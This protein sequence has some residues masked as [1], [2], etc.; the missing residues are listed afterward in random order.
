MTSFYGNLTALGDVLAGTLPLVPAVFL[1]AAGCSSEGFRLHLLCSR[2]SSVGSSCSGS[3]WRESR[4]SLWVAA[5]RRSMAVKSALPFRC[6]H[7]TILS[8][9]ALVVISLH[10]VP[11][12]FA[13]GEMLISCPIV[14]RPF[15]I[16]LISSMYSGCF[17]VRSS[18]FLSKDARISA[19]RFP[20]AV[21]PAISMVL[22]E[23]S[24]TETGRP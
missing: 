3:G 19:Y 17:A 11:F 1:R 16:S 18:I 10:T 21:G 6:L 9:S 15:R 14:I 4:N 2:N 13:R 8:A 7:S 20:H 24:P 23:S 22:W 12:P 5:Y